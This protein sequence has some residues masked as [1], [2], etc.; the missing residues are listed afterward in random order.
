MLNE[1]DIKEFNFTYPYTEVPVLDNINLSIKQGE[2]FVICGYSG[3]GKTTL[4]KHLKSV[5]ELNGDK[6][7]QIFFQGRDI[8][9]ISSEE[10]IKKIGFVL[11]NVEAQIVT[12]KVWHE[13]AFGLEGLGYDDNLI[14]KRVAE[15]SEFFGLYNV[16][17]K[18]TDELSGGEKQLLNLASVMITNPSVLILDEPASQLD[19]I[20][21]TEFF[22]CISKINREFGT[23]II[24]AEHDLEEIIGLCTRAAVMDKGKIICVGTPYEVG[25]Y[26]NEIEHGMLDALPVPMRVYETLKDNSE[27]NNICPITVGQGKRWLENYCSKNGINKNADIKLNV[28]DEVNSNRNTIIELDEV[29][30][31]Y[32]NNTND[33][34]KGMSLKI[35][36]GEIFS[37]LGGNGTGKTT[38]LSIIAGNYI[39]YRG[40]VKIGYNHKKNLNNKKNINIGMIPQMP[41]LMFS[42]KT[43][44]AELSEVINQHTDISFDEVINLCQ[45]DGCMDRHP[46]DLSG[47]EKQKLALAKILL[48]NSSIVLMDEPSKG[49][50]AQF[51]K[52]FGKIL[53]KMQKKG[54]T[55]VLVSHDVEFCAEYSDRCA[56]VFDGSIVSMDVAKSFF[57]GNS[58]Y[59]TAANRMARNIFPM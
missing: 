50:D 52:V 6:S 22:S 33:V 48:L 27:G 16:M 56:M 3:C 1:Y 39:P 9:D 54:I 57:A 21:R 4:L 17:G 11:Q 15:M 20:A 32:E 10:Q 12:D 29:W 31:K 35:R 19:P 14:R 59:T 36:E 18:K 2:F 44:K 24:V 40:K 45:L 53:R 23:T 8:S 51:K 38:A 26:L 28:T 25:E 43:V 7:G 47:G 49:M 37:I 42:Q 5:F 30:F 58:F 41:E 13:L 34:L 46:F 55:I